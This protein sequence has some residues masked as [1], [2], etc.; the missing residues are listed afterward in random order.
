[1][2]IIGERINSSRKR[3]AEAMSCRDKNFIQSEAKAQA[4]A[5]AHYID[6]NAGAFIGEEAEYLKWT[7]D[8]VQ[9]ACDLP[10]C[11]DSPDAG[12][13]REVLP[14]VGITPMINSI[15]L[16]PVRLEGMLPLI[17]DFKAKVIGLCQSED[18]MA[19][20]TEAKIEMASQLAEKVKLAGIP[21]DNLYIDPLVYPLGTNT[22]S[23]VATLDAIAYIMQEFSGIHTVCGLTNISH[24]LPCRKLINRSFLVSAIIRGLDAAIMDPTDKQLYGSLRAAV[25]VAG[26][27]EFCNEYIRAFRAGS[28]G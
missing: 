28:L 7:M 27:D 6:V 4:E 18:L 20:S 15:T 1:M 16:E 22:K 26:E 14:L 21:L 5:G 11:I 24:G 13:I 25:A 9:E 10:L 3:I 19:D 12:V 8:A 2:L 23:A 17:V